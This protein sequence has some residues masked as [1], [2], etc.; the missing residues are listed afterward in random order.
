MPPCTLS[1]AL[2]L[3]PAFKQNKR[4]SYLRD[5]WLQKPL[6]SQSADLQ[7]LWVPF[8][9]DGGRSA[10]HVYCEVEDKEYVR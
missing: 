8:Q 4:D 2:F 10:G 9:Q 1:S 6:H 3:F 7:T 5:Q